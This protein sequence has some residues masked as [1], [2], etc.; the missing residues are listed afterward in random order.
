MNTT[1]PNTKKRRESTSVIKNVRLEGVSALKA[2]KVTSVIE[3]QYDL[4][5]NTGHPQSMHREPVGQII[6]HLS[7]ELVEV[8][9][10]EVA[11]YRKNGTP[12]F[13]LKKDGKLYIAKIPR[14]ISFVTFTLLNTHRCSII[15]NECRRLSAA[16]D[17][18]GG[19]AKVRDHATGIERYPWITLGYETFC[20]LHDSFVVA[21]CLHYEKCTPRKAVSQVV[22]NNLKLGLAQFVWDDVTNRE[23]VKKRVNANLEH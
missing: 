3:V 10:H 23:E 8:S 14:N 19:C 11:E 16:S 20:T 12:S 6:E 2:D 4:Q 7:F 18:D 17:K 9:P 13:L 1:T 15:G 5:P 22:S 21:E